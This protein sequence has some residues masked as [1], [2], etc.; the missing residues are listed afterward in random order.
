MR[1]DFVLLYQRLAAASR[2]AKRRPKSEGHDKNTHL[3]ET[4]NFCKHKGASQ[5]S[6]KPEDDCLFKF[7]PVYRFVLNCVA[8]VTAALNTTVHYPP[9]TTLKPTPSLF[10]CIVSVS[11]PSEMANVH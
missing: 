6:G 3:P 9:L 11:R 5:H 1:F 4:L 10:S 8:W 7:R 2:Q